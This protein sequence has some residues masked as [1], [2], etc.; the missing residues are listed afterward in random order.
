MSKTLSDLLG[1]EDNKSLLEPDS[2]TPNWL[3]NNQHWLRVVLTSLGDAVI[4]CDSKKKVSFLNPVGASLTGWDADE[5]I[6]QPMSLVFRTVNEHTNEPSADILEEVLSTG[7]TVA[8]ANH[9]ALINRQGEAIPIEDSAAPILDAEGQVAGVV[10]VFHDVTQRRR[11][12]EALEHS[13]KRY[14]SLFDNMGEGF[15]LHEII[16]NEQGQ[17]CDYRF[18]EVNPAFEA[19]TGLSRHDVVG[20]QITKILPNDDPK[21]VEIY[22]KVALTGEPVQFDNYSPALKRHYEVYAYRPAPMQFATI[23]L[24]V[25][26]KKRSQDQLR[27]QAFQ[28]RE[29]SDLLDLAHVLARDLHDN[30]ILWNHGAE[31]MYGW[32]RAEALGSQSHILFQT[33]FAEPLESIRTKLFENGLWQGELIHTCKS[34]KKITVASHWVLHRNSGGEPVAILEVN[35]DITERKSAEQALK[36][37]EE[38]AWNQ[39]V[40]LKTTIDAAPTIIWTAHDRDC[41]LITG[42]RAA[43]Q[44]LGVPEDTNMSGTGANSQSLT[45]FRI[46]ADGTELATNDLPLQRV[47][48]S[49]KPIYNS[50]IDIVFNDGHIRSLLGNVVP[51]FDVAGETRGAIAAYVD[52][53]TRKNSETALEHYLQKQLEIISASTTIL[54]QHNMEDLLNVISETAC[55]LT[56]AQMACCGHG[57]L[58]KTFRVGG[59]WNQENAAVCQMSGENSR[60]LMDRGGVYMEVMEHAATLRLSDEEMRGH[61][62]WWGLPDGHVPLQGL[63]AARLVDADGLPSGVIMLSHKTVGDFTRED[64]A[65]LGQMATIASLALQH[66]EARQG[67]EQARDN[68]EERVTERTADLE[69][70]NRIIQMVS[71]C[72]EALVRSSNETVMIRE[73]CRIILN[74]GRHVMAW[75]GMAQDDELRSVRPVICVGSNIDYITNMRISWADNERG[76]GPT[77]SAIRLGKPIIGRNF[78]KDPELAPWREEA[79]KRGFNSSIALPLTHNGKTFGALTIYSKHPDFFDNQ[80]A[81]ILGELAENLAFGI[82]AIRTRKELQDRSQ[83]LREL[84]AELTQAEEKERRRLAEILHDDL[85]QVLVG[86]KC[87]LGILRRRIESA[88]EPMAVQVDQLLDEAI[89]KSRSLSYELSSPVLRQHGFTA[90]LNWLSRQMLEKYQFIVTIQAQDEAEPREDNLCIFLFKCVQELLLNAIKHA[91]TTEATVELFVQ[92]EQILISVSDKGKGFN[93]SILSHDPNRRAGIGLFSIRE[94]ISFIGGRFDL[95]SRP[96]EGSRFT[97]SVP[98]NKNFVVSFDRISSRSQQAAAVDSRN[99]RQPQVIRVLLVDDHKVMRQGLRT[100]L[101]DEDDVEIIAEAGNGVEALA[102][103]AEL[104]PDVV[105]MDVAMPLMDGIQATR[106]IKILFPEVRIVGLSMF[107]FEDMAEKMIAAGAD[108]YVSKAGP[109]EDLIAALHR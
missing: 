62:R 73:V 37:S 84:A 27:L 49:G 77:G 89:D 71:E 91:G 106:E 24:D 93:P 39:A 23:F 70:R 4:A 40:Q 88:Q 99:P 79:L 82:M 52:I 12:Q 69:A 35:N 21:W 51:I 46:F 101:Q 74:R 66:L 6:G 48:A 102:L 43:E 94:R 86:A 29:Q 56:Q 87:H 17:P 108:T 8:L 100:L 81:R 68:L 14:R 22:G 90:A 103:V 3:P 64:E 60:F 92:D 104:H 25:T 47:A 13:E 26:D 19:L 9:T 33:V 65:L 41:H 45:H 1:H 75:V 61:E 97:I 72:N 57:F 55:S 76:R 54:Q 38:R 50:A 58:D 34:G 32:T 96:G 78:A 28:L 44:L 10:L 98:Q 7:K 67:I 53:T 18:L 107:E 42:N 36:S 20:K 15:A 16:C 83:Q 105:V 11:Q 5:A 80:Q 30:I 85:Q 109:S 63:L 31:Q 59:S 2:A 95:H